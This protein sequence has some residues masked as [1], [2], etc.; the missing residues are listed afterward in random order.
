MATRQPAVA[1]SF[2]TADASR[3]ADEVG[4]LLDTATSPRPGSSP[5]ALIAP[6]AGYIYSGPVAA[7]AYRMLRQAAGAITRVVVL[8]P[9]HRVYLAGV[10][11]P[12]V[13]HFATPLGEIALDGHAIEALRELPQVSVSD[14]AH[15]HEHSIEVQLPFLQTVLGEFQLVPIVVG[16][17]DSAAAAEVI[18]TVWGGAE[19][20]IVVSSDL[21][22]YLPYQTARAADADT[23]RAIVAYSH[24]LG[25]EQACGAHA[26]NGLMLVAARH[27]LGVEQ[28]DLRNSGDTAGDRSQVVGYGAF[29]LY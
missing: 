16:E 21:S 27:G 26:I 10:A 22:H 28:L 24:T 11:V 9:A 12:C 29:A 1:G 13:E 14:R 5:K 7:N 19:T 3:L 17:C 20:L 4:Q 23:S 25:G 18:E 8:G 15:R 6:H 2:Y